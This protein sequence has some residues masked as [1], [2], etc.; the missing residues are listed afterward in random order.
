MAREKVLSLQV[1]RFYA[2]L[3]VLLSHVEGY[4]VAHGASHG[5]SVPAVGI[6]GRLGVEI[7]FVIS[8]FIMGWLSLDLFGKAGAAQQ[9]ALDRV[10]RIVPLYWVCTFAAAGLFLLKQKLGPGGDPVPPVA[11]LLKSFFFYP[12]NAEGVHRPVLA[13]GWT[14]DFEMLFYG[15][16]A[17]CLMLSRSWATVALISAFLVIY[18]LGFVPGMPAPFQ[19]W[20]DPI[21]FDFLAGFILAL[22][23][24]RWG[25][26]LRIG[27]HPLLL[28]AGIALTTTLLVTTWGAPVFSMAS[29]LLVAL[30]TLG[31]DIRTGHGNGALVRMGDWSYSL[32]LTHIFA[33]SLLAM[34]WRKFFGGE[35]LWFYATL[36]ILVPIAVSAIVFHRLEMPMTRLLRRRL[37]A[38]SIT[39]GLAP[40]GA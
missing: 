3:V 36:N 16:F 4:V 10:T 22:I 39:A 9:F 18:L 19:V 24:G 35:W 11:D 25:V 2:A 32:Y 21:I 15:I 12:V 28:L 27:G 17:F 30:C 34:A 31:P 23:R 1:L 26:V 37:G 14:L 33:L 7:F 6:S 29:I 40:K 38:R 5:V 20:A 13:Q 8:G